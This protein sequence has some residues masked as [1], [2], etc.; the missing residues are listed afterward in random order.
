MTSP[1][2]ESRSARAS[3]R[4]R[5]AR[6]RRARADR[7]GNAR[8]ARG[9]SLL[10][11]IVLALTVAAGQ[12]AA[13]PAPGDPALA[14]KARALQGELDRRLDAVERLTEQV[15]ASEERRVQFE[16]RLI[17]L[18]T[19]QRAI[20]AELAAAKAQ[21]D[22][23]ARATYMRSPEW[24]LDEVLRGSGPP[25]VPPP[26][27]DLEVKAAAVTLVSRR[28]ADQERMERQTSFELAAAQSVRDRYAA[29][30]DRL[31]AAVTGMQATLK[32]IDRRLGGFLEAEEVRAEAARRAAY[33]G[34]VAGVGPVDSWVR[35]GRAARAAVGWALAQVG[36]P[37]RWG[38][39]GPAAFDCSG[40][41]SSAYRAAGVAIPRTSLAQWGAGLH[42]NVPELLPGDLVFY[43]D[44][45]GN[46]GTIHHVGLYIG[47]GLMVHAPHT[48]DVVRVASIWR[49]GYVGAVRVVPGVV[50]PGAPPRHAPVTP[51]A[52]VA[53]PPPPPMT[54]APART[55]PP[56][57]TR[58]PVVPTTTTAPP[59][60]TPPA[61]TTTVPPTTTTVP[62]ATSTVPPATSAVPPETAPPTTAAPPATEVATTTPAPN[63][64]AVAV[65]GR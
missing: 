19:R 46:P 51:P 22:E 64:Q 12:A 55:T 45:A 20:G 18:R 29:E 15:N 11:S 41:T 47:N 1:G 17:G 39:S 13:D 14:A 24:L 37:Y 56:P 31:Q 23:L 53:P 32:Q 38:A 59:E 30:R 35:A 7:P 65:A 25:R 43:G 2:P 44:Q 58:P 40:L 33:A 8:A 52:T 34:Y 3:R 49:E 36:D 60:T 26:L 63:Q 28:M 50:R 9:G 57:T 10:A 42:P 54:T 4:R 21:L 5:Q 16:P 61:T 6:G 27:A 62:P 48:G